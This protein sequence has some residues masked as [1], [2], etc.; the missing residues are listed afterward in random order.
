MAMT[1]PALRSEKKWAAPLARLRALGGHL[2]GEVLHLRDGLALGA[3]APPIWKRL[4][5]SVG[6]QMI[7]GLTWL[8]TGLMIY[9]WVFNITNMA[10]MG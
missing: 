7:N 2:P 1:E 5:F 9:P 6:D 3:E 4:A 10:N 8:K